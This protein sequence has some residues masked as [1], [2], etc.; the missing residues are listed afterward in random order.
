MKKIYLRIITIAFLSILFSCNKEEKEEK[1]ELIPSTTNE[2]VYYVKYEIS[3]RLYFYIDG[4]SY[5]TENGFQSQSF[6]AARSFEETCGPV[7]KGFSAQ[8][9]ITQRR[10]EPS[11]GATKIYVS[12]NNGPFA[13]KATGKESASYTINF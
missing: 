6:S 11:S 4:V 10:G 8:I 5:K 3:G 12:K 13:I 7:K 2:D 9:Q 1:E